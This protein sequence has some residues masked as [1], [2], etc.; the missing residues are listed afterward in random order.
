MSSQFFDICIGFLRTFITR[1][2]QSL[3]LVQRKPIWTLFLP[4]LHVLRQRLTYWRRRKCRTWTNWSW[5]LVALVFLKTGKGMISSLY[6]AE[7]KTWRASLISSIDSTRLSF[8]Y[9]MVRR[10]FENTYDKVG[11]EQ[12]QLF[13]CPGQFRFDFWNNVLCLLQHF[14][15]FWDKLYGRMY[16]FLDVPFVLFGVRLHSF[17][18][19]FLCNEF[20]LVWNEFLFK[21]LRVR[22]LG[23]AVTV[24]QC[25]SWFWRL[26]ACCSLWLPFFCLNIRN[27]LMMVGRTRDGWIVAVLDSRIGVHGTPLINNLMT[28]FRE[29]LGISGPLFTSSL[30]RFRRNIHSLMR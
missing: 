25:L 26:W 29:K 5:M 15:L 2:I 23:N 30:K 21:A 24:S 28:A 22:L 13:T 17:D 16:L 18:A 10:D 11:Y 19:L 3:L 6:C 27:L 14:N 9:M 12:I 4:T 7:A 1:I 20:F 8:A